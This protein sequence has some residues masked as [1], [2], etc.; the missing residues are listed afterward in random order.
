MGERKINRA[1]CKMRTD[2]VLVDVMLLLLQILVLL[3][4]KITIDP[5]YS[6]ISIPC[7]EVNLI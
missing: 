7:G 1:E 6:S 4:Q 2:F 3:R 5:R